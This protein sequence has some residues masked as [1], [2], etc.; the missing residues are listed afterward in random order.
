MCGM[1]GRDGDDGVND[2]DVERRAWSGAEGRSKCDVRRC[3]DAR[4]RWLLTLAC[5]GLVA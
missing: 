2:A 5:V 4:A 1:D 3:A